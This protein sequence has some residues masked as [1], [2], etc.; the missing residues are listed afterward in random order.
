MYVQYKVCLQCMYNAHAVYNV[1]TVHKVH[2]CTRNLYTN[3]LA[4]STL[5][6]LC[7]MYVQY[8]LSL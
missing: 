7:I 5:H 1:W 3:S 6:Y 8:T 4:I 2:F